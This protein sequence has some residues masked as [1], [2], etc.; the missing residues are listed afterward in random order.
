MK[1]KRNPVEFNYSSR[2]LTPRK[3]EKVQEEKVTFTP[4][5]I[6]GKFDA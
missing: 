5:K 3:P 2:N 1:F 6:I 4:L